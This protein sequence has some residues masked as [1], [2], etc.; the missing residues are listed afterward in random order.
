LAGADPFAAFAGAF[1]AGALV[2]VRFTVSS[3]AGPALVAATYTLSVV[4]TPVGTDV[5]HPKRLLCRMW[6]CHL[7]GITRRYP[8]G[9]RR[10]PL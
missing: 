4:R 1:L 5:R 2:A 9:G 6:R 7:L 10:Q 3:V 8:V